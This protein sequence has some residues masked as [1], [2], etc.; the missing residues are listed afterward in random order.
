MAR[1][2]HRRK[3]QRGAAQPATDG[4][5]GGAPEGGAPE[6]GA[7]EG[8]APES[9]AP[10]PAPAKA[11]EPA[12]E[13]LVPW[14]MR[15]TA[16]GNCVRDW[17]RLHYAEALDAWLRERFEDPDAAAH[18]ADVGQA[19]DDFVCSAGSSGDAP[20]ILSVWCGQVASGQIPV[21]E[22]GGAT[23]EDVAQVRRWE[24]ERHRGVFILQRAQRDQLS[25]WDPLE[26]APLTL[27]LLT[28]LG[29]AECDALQRG[30]VVTAV[31]Q[32]WMARLVA[33]G[34]EYFSDPRAVQLFREQTLDAER[35][36]HEAPAPAPTP[37]RAKKRSSV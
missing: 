7:P 27:H 2:R 29:A 33:V 10:K 13:A 21:S 30:T 11:A 17:S 20:S 6:G 35:A 5:E 36:W 3:K 31:Y 37:T 15:M 26:G 23:D 16:L 8:G 32:P 4:P 18:A 12:G 14:R 28:R 25:L 9:P 34:A 1:R 19:V 24:R 22:L